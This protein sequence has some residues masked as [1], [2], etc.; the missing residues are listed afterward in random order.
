MTEK[1]NTFFSSEEVARKEADKFALEMLH[2]GLLVKYSEGEVIP[3]GETDAVPADMIDVWYAEDQKERHKLRRFKW[4]APLEIGDVC[5]VRD[6]EN[7]QGDLRIFNGIY[8]EDSAPMF[9]NP[10]NE[11]AFFWVC[12]EKTGFNI[13]TKTY[14]PQE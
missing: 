4:A 13:I 10:D 8:N 5:V 1:D 3:A 6:G 11:T 9:S 7:R 12:Y 2:S 14:T